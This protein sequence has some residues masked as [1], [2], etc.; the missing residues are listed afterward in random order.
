VARGVIF[1]KT[2]SVERYSSTAG[3]NARPRSDCAMPALSV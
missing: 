3:R 1:A 2:D